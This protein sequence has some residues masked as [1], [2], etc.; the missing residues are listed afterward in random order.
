[1]AASSSSVASSSSS[2]S[3]IPPRPRVSSSYLISPTPLLSPT[4]ATLSSSISSASRSLSLAST[5]ESSQHPRRYEL[6]YP[7]Y[8]RAARAFLWAVRNLTPQGESGTLEE[9]EREKLGRLKENLKR[10]AGRAL[11]RAERI[12]E[13]KGAEWARRW[14]GMSSRGGG[15]GGGGCK[16]VEEQGRRLVDSSRINGLLCEPWSSSSY[17]SFSRTGATLETFPLPLLSEKQRLTGAKLISASRIFTEEERRGCCL[18]DPARPLRGEDITQDAVSNC[19]LVA[20]MEVIAEHDF[21]WQTKLLRQPLL[22]EKDELEASVTADHIYTARLHLNGCLRLVH[23][24]DQLPFYEASDA[25]SSSSAGS[26]SFPSRQRRLM[27]ASVRSSSAASPDIDPAPA[28]ILTSLVEKACLSVLRTYAPPG[29]V[30]AEDLYLLTGWLPEVVHLQARE[31]DSSSSS[32]DP[33]A[34]SGMGESQGRHGPLSSS[35]QREKTF[36]RVSQAWVKGWVLVCAGTGSGTSSRESGEATATGIERGLVPSHSYAVLELQDEQQ[37]GSERY[38]KLMNPW[39]PANVPQPGEEGKNSRTT[40]APP[41]SLHLTTSVSTLGGKDSPFTLS[42]ERFLH[43]FSTLHLAWNPLALFTYMD[44]VHGS[45]ERG[46]EA[47][48]DIGTT[49]ASAGAGEE[50][51]VTLQSEEGREGRAAAVRD[52]TFTLRVTGPPTGSAQ[53][54][55]HED[56]GLDRGPGEGAGE[57]WLHLTRHSKETRSSTSSEGLDGEPTVNRQEE[58]R[59]IAIHIYESTAGGSEG[60]QS[61]RVMPLGGERGSSAGGIYVNTC[62][63]LVRFKP[64]FF[65]DSLLRSDQPLSA[66]TARASKEYQIV[67]SLHAPLEEEGEHVNFTLRAWSR[68]EVSLDEVEQQPGWTSELR[69]SWTTS[70]SGGHLD[71]PSFP[72]NPQYLLTLPPSSP[73]TSLTL[74]LSATPPLPIHILVVHSPPLTAHTSRVVR[75]DRAEQ[76]DVVAQSGEYTY[77]F[78]RVKILLPPTARD[79]GGHYHVVLSTYNP[80]VEGDFKLRIE[81]MARVIVSER[82]ISTLPNT[83]AGV[84]GAQGAL[85]LSP[86]SMEGAGMFAKR[87]RGRWAHADG[88]AGGAPRYARYDSNPSWVIRLMGNSQQQP[89]ARA[90]FRLRA[91]ASVQVLRGE[92]S[93]DQAASPPE[94]RSL[95]PINLSLFLVPP[96]YVEQP[97][98]LL[99]DSGRVPAPLATTDRYTVSPAGVALHDVRLK[100]GEVYL[101]VASCFES[102]EAGQGEFTLLGWCA[103]RAWTM[104]RL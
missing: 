61:T 78:A 35:I 100:R 46:D 39:R 53:D 13:V 82:T 62:H 43:S 45:W 52:T 72:S 81:G 8:L 37:S 49:S 41:S 28:I 85:L 65:L 59:F 104:D 22:V 96:Q 42:W 103:E 14:G 101:A 50:G 12:R 79:R 36:R 57:V 56:S 69:G 3:T 16:D 90:T 71:C 54:R 10:Q 76:A 98:L 64:S 23:I 33:Q 34:S 2:T 38:L 6:A 27:C 58:K 91:E 51:G 20:A 75:V 83:L 17:S 60:Y 18:W 74:T 99:R 21:K 68:Y 73:A 24:D 1:M 32:S 48:A 26:S 11:Q 7:I 94:A 63:H 25:S 47:T 88:T 77:G 5:H 89:F 4:P 84:E 31:D 55:G 102:G 66:Q 19:G 15:G 95:P 80:G 67:L 97:S 87:E 44:E 86:I 70:T 92:P 30:P 93:Q 29:S 9:E 40:P